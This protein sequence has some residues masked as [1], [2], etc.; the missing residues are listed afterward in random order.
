VTWTFASYERVAADSD[1]LVLPW[2]TLKA[3]VKW[4]W[5][6]E[7]GLEWQTYQDEA[8][9]SARRALQSGRSAREVSLTPSRGTALINY[10]SIPD[11]GFG[12]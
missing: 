3:G 11:G 2:Q 8:I 7:N 5:K 9:N 12:N 1:V 6:R 4:R 10:W